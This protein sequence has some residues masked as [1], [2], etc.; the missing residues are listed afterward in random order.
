MRSVMRTGTSFAVVPM[1][2]L[3]TGCLGGAS[4]DAGTDGGFPD[5]PVVLVEPTHVVEEGEDL[6]LLLALR[7]DPWPMTLDDYLETLEVEAYDATTGELAW[8]DRE[9]IPWG[10]LGLDVAVG[11]AD[12]RTGVIE[13]RMRRRET[14][15]RFDYDPRSEAWVTPIDEDLW[16]VG[17][18][19]LDFGAFDVRRA[20]GSTAFSERIFGRDSVESFCYQPGPIRPPIGPRTVV[21]TLTRGPGGTLVLDAIRYGPP[22]QRLREIS[23]PEP[24]GSLRSE[25]V[26]EFFE[27]RIDGVRDVF[28][29]EVETG[30][31]AALGERHAPPGVDHLRLGPGEGSVQGGCDPDH[32]AARTCRR[33]A[34]A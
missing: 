2:V 26:R 27:R 22:E 1:V 30:G 3:L 29:V 25:Y 20:C 7:L 4:S 8:T 9:E 18:D 15:A 6:G 23:H 13:M 12:P 32:A 11:T 17:Y 19:P 16:G 31:V 14:D 28:V 24:D 5:T 33:C 34:A 10:H 21:G